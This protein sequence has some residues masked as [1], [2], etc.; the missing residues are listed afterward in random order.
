MIGQT[1]NQPATP[2]SANAASTPTQGTTATTATTATTVAAAADNKDTNDNKTEYQTLSTVVIV[3]DELGAIHRKEPLQNGLF[4]RVHYKDLLPTSFQICDAAETTVYCQKDFPSS[5]YGI[6]IMPSNHFYYCGSLREADL[7]GVLQVTGEINTDGVTHNI[8]FKTTITEHSILSPHQP[9]RGSYIG[10]S[11]TEALETGDM[12]LQF[13]FQ[14]KFLRL[15]LQGF[16]AAFE[17]YKNMNDVFQQNSPAENPKGFITLVKHIHDGLNSH[18]KSILKRVLETAESTKP[19]NFLHNFN[20]TLFYHCIPADQIIANLDTSALNVSRDIN[21]QVIIPSKEGVVITR[22]NKL[23]FWRYDDKQSDD[24]SGAKKQY[25]HSEIK[26]LPQT[27]SA[28][29]SFLIGNNQFALT[30]PLSAGVGVETRDFMTQSITACYL[31][32]DQTIDSSVRQ[33]LLRNERGGV[34]IQPLSNGTTFV[35]ELH[36]TEKRKEVSCFGSHIMFFNIATKEVTSTTY[37]SKD[38]NPFTLRLTVLPDDSVFVACSSNI[39]K[40][41]SDSFVCSYSPLSLILAIRQLLEQEEEIAFPP[42]LVNIIFHY[43]GFLKDTVNKSKVDLDERIAITDSLKEI[44]ILTTLI[45]DIILQC[46][47]LLT[48]EVNVDDKSAV[49]IDAGMPHKF[50]DSAD[51]VDVDDRFVVVTTHAALLRRYGGPAHV[52][53]ATSIITIEELPLTETAANT[54]ASATTNT[55]AS[56]TTATVA[57]LPPP[58]APIP[59]K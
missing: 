16:L 4:V 53:R 21:T 12:L 15:T 17:N 22:G 10:I 58:S 57:S 7:E 3:R 26:T 33:T 49:T 50:G 20:S 52:G 29:S 43:M 59:K 36:F 24:K 42:V 47:D 2:A 5:H 34:D 13:S 51:E 32:R 48:D 25:P 6:Y 31:I 46:M 39:S 27:P 45:I 9:G 56:A 41:L 37:Y 14:P 19:E 11:A 44:G 18:L 38:R 23:G 28:S 40:V 55:A 1:T 8:A 35:G 54:A 30:Y